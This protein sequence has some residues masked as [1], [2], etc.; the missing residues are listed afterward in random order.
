MKKVIY[1]VGIF[2][3]NCFLYAQIVINPSEFIFSGD[4]GNGYYKN[5]II[6]SDFSDPDV[7][8]VGTNYYM[9]ASSFNCIPGLPILHSRD[10]VNWKLITY[11]I[12]SLPSPIYDVPQ[13]G[14]GC[15]APSI[16]F[17]NG[18]Y[19]IFFGDPDL[20]IFVTTAYDP[21]GPWSPLRLIKKAK[22]WIDPCPFWDDNGDMYIIHAW[23][24]SRVGFN[25]ILTIRKVN[26]DNLI[27]GDDS[28]NVV[29]D[30]VQHPTLEGPKLYK[31]NGYYYIFAPAGGV[32]N[33]WQVVFRSKN[34]YGPY[35]FRKVLDQGLTDINGPHQGAW[36][37]TPYGESWFI[38]F[39]DKDAYGR[40]IH[41]Q[42][43]A[44]EDDFPKIGLDFNGD[45]I[46]EPV[47]EYKKSGLNK[48]KFD[49]VFT[50]L[51]SFNE[52]KLSLLWQWHANPK[53]NWYTFLDKTNQLLLNS[54]YFKNVNNLW[55][56]PN[57]LLQKFY[58]EEFS[59]QTAIDFELLGENELAGLVVMGKDYSYLGIKK[60][61]S[62]F[63]LIKAV[64][65]NADK[66]NVEFV[67]DEKIINK[68]KLTFKVDV[69][70][71]AMCEFSYS[72]D[73]KNFFN[74]GNIFKAR[75]GEWIGSK[76]GLFT[77]S[78]EISKKNGNIKISYFKTTIYNKSI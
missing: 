52:L 63:K 58:S 60:E 39:Q 42:P 33:G 54:I 46:G 74:I 37:E 40:I 78:K 50:I 9:T 36:V 18:M 21:H 61:G 69:K 23:A 30:S 13:H 35:E 38:H 25:S 51:D 45:G 62:K 76:V 71:N 7:I 48:Q 47:K 12:D 56:L 28:V 29:N 65:L 17:R 59:I 8:R 1:I 20:G 77:Y 73:N 15:W 34:I 43:L 72:F 6:H 2:I 4:L 14:K 44:W 75:K 5:P 55:D 24:K 19:Y 68:T 53:N 27:I 70:K 49:S 64:C 67:E 11:A 32:K 16:R 57:L 41:L 10:L 22:G 26:P 3:F 66:R 31:R